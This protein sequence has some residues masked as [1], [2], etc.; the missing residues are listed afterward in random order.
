MEYCD[1][2]CESC[3]I[4]PK[5]SFCC[6]NCDKHCFCDDEDLICVECLLSNLKKKL[7]NKNKSCDNSILDKIIEKEFEYNDPNIEGLFLNEY[8][9]KHFFKT[10]MKNVEHKIDLIVDKKKLFPNGT[11]Y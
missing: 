1:C 7:K 3:N 9:K 11:L 4:L 5:A 10:K 6:I 2:D 8:Q